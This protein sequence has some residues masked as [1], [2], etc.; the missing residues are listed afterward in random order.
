MDK[1]ILN[2]DKNADKW[3]SP[4][5]ANPQ[6]LGITS[7]GQ[8]AQLVEQRTENPCVGGS[9]PPLATSNTKGLRDIQKV[10]Y[11]ICLHFCLHSESIYSYNLF[12]IKGPVSRVSSP[13]R[14]EY[15]S[16][17]SRDIC[18]KFP[19]YLLRVTPTNSSQ[20]DTLQVKSSYLVI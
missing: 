1:L 3:V 2:A 6:T 10:E 5:L 14:C 4:K 19:L 7:N 11:Y 13:L 16:S 18:L 8:I 12:V 15:N 17:K 20:S 9:I